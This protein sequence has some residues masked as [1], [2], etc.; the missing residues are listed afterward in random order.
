MSYKVKFQNEPAYKSMPYGGNSIYN[1]ACG[2]ASLCNALDVLGIADVG[3]P[4]MCELAVSCGARMD[5]GTECK[6]EL[7]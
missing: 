7:E 2:P 6:I 1:S 4:T 5:G 3:I